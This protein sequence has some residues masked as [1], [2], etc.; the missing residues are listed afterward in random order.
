MV[1]RISAHL[2]TCS[3]IPLENWL[4][5]EFNYKNVKLNDLEPAIAY[6]SNHRIEYWHGHYTLSEPGALFGFLNIT[7]DDVEVNGVSIKN[8]IYDNGTL[9]WEAQPD[10]PM[11]GTL[12]FVQ[13][14]EASP[15]MVKKGHFGKSV[16]GSIGLLGSEKMPAR[17][18][19]VNGSTAIFW[20]EPSSQSLPES[21][22][23]LRGMM[24]SAAITASANEAGAES[25]PSFS[26]WNGKYNVTV[27]GDATTHAFEL[28]LVDFKGIIHFDSNAFSVSDYSSEDAMNANRHS[29]LTTLTWDDSTGP[30]KTKGEII[31]SKS[32]SNVMSFT[33]TLIQDAGTSKSVSGISAK[34]NNLDLWNGVYVMG[35]FPSGSSTFPKLSLNLINGIGDIYYGGIKL[36]EENY[37][38]FGDYNTNGMR[39]QNTLVWDDTQGKTK[40][41]GQLEFSLNDE[42]QAVCVGWI[43]NVDDTDAKNNVCGALE[44]EKGEPPSLTDWFV[45]VG[46]VVGTTIAAAALIVGG[47]ALHPVIRDMKAH[48]AAKKLAKSNPSPQNNHALILADVAVRKSFDD[49]DFELDM[50][51][52]KSGLDIP[53]DQKQIDLQKESA[54]E[55][56][57]KYEGESLRI[58]RDVVRA[59]DA[60][61]EIDGNIKAMEK[62]IQKQDNIIKDKNSSDAEIK[63]AKETREKLKS[64]QENNYVDHDVQEKKSVDANKKLKE[65]EKRKKRETLRKET[66]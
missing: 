15:T 66:L 62:E 40:T 36:T 52:E 48:Y 64:D 56:L 61:I 30:S 50:I 27:A 23:F 14:G 53:V 37:A 9:T 29:G 4:N 39:S 26:Q 44:V 58:A 3:E 8:Y 31:F 6:F 17:T 16:S 2:K 10:A 42:K 19:Q 49:S 63:K 59:V 1:R 24:R 38:V 45:I 47:I 5:T 25:E 13:L 18:L 7:E 51:N 32:N 43:R 21:H 35:P 57:N 65:L 28:E 54:K 55:F 41:H 46:T 33:G 60:K 11:S 22:R 34:L 12:R 20:F